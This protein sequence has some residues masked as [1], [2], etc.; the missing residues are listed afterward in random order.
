MIIEY[1]AFL[2][3]I[4]GICASVAILGLALFLCLIFQ[5]A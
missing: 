3:C 5:L 2:G 1:N 4:E